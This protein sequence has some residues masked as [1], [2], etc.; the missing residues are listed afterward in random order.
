MFL[1]SFIVFLCNN[2][3]STTHGGF[4]F[5]LLWFSNNN[6]SF[7]WFIGW[8]RVIFIIS[9]IIIAQNYVVST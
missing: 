8:I 9:F 5:N 6:D 2:I 4:H 3:L 7:G 1:F